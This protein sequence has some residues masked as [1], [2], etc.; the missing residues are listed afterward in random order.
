MKT[1]SE[2]RDDVA[3]ELDWEPGV[4]H[5]DID[6]DVNDGLVTLSGV[7][8]SYAKKIYAEMAAERINGVN[9][10]INNLQVDLARHHLRDDEEIASAVKTALRWSASV[11]DENIT[12]QVNDGWVTLTGDTEWNYQKDKARKIAEDII[13]V[14]GVTNEI[15]LTSTLPTTSDVKEKISAA[16]KRSLDFDE[17]RVHV[18]VHGHAVMLTGKVNSI[19]EKNKAERAAWSAPGVKEVQN[20]LQVSFT[21]PY[22]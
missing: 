19:S 12:V 4:K 21:K 8:D 5:K 9:G 3:E 15:K 1:D 7:V 20:N 10:V 14:R 11:P 17:T 16:L 2:I 22:S 13:G 18:E 6:V